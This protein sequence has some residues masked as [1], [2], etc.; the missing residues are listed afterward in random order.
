[1]KT[2]ARVRFCEGFIKTLKN[3][4]DFPDLRMY[5]SHWADTIEADDTILCKVVDDTNIK[6]GQPKK[7]LDI[8]LSLFD[9]FFNVSCEEEKRE[10]EN[11]WSMV[12]NKIDRQIIN[13]VK[14]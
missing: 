4:K 11:L 8:E 13:I 10:R 5:C 12:N 9:Y 2:I 6:T 14:I 3:T 7:S 1:M